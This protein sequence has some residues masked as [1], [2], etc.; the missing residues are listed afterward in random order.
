VRWTQFDSI[1]EYERIVRAA[2]QV[3]GDLALAEWE[4]RVFNNAMARQ[5]LPTDR[6][7]RALPTVTSF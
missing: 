2:K 5:A 3:A 7:R 6:R 1:D 4:L